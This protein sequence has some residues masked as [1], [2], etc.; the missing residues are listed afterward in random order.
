MGMGAPMMQLPQM[1]MFPAS[2]PQQMAPQMQMQMTPNATPIG[3]QS[4]DPRPQPDTPMPPNNP[5]D[6]LQSQDER[7]RKL[8]HGRVDQEIEEEDDANE[9]SGDK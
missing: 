6:S 7:T 8:Q 2:M 1:P 4:S 9:E 5:R 3:Y